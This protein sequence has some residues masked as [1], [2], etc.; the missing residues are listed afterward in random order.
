MCI[1]WEIKDFLCIQE[2]PQAFG[3][4]NG[5]VHW[6]IGLATDSL[7][8]YSITGN[9]LQYLLKPAPECDCKINSISTSFVL[10][11]LWNWDDIHFGIFPFGQDKHDTK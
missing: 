2:S 9:G 5:K 4:A 10:E 6:R 1:N 8:D 7:D 3:P 11:F